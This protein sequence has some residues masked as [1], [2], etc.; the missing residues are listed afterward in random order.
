MGLAPELQIYAFVVLVKQFV[1]KVVHKWRSMH[2]GTS[3]TKRSEF[4]QEVKL[5]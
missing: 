4:R 2:P 5:S 1:H 3:R